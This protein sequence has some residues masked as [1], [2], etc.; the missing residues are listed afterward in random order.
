MMLRNRN[1]PVLMTAFGLAAISLAACDDAYRIAGEATKGG[2][3]SGPDGGSSASGGS[4]G[5]G[6]SSATGGATG[7]TG[8][9]GGQPVCKSDVIAVKGLCQDLGAFKQQAY[10]ACDEAGLSLNDYVPY[11]S[12]GTDSYYSVRYVCCPKPEA[13]PPPP[14]QCETGWKT[15]GGDSSCKPAGD[16]KQYAGED[17]EA[18]GTN[19]TAYSP[20]D[21]C[22]E[23]NYRSVQYCCGPTRPLPTT[24]PPSDCTTSSQGDGSS[25][26]PV[27]KWMQDAG[28]DCA[29]RGAILTAYSPYD[30]CGYG[31]YRS[32]EYTC[33]A[34][35]S[36]K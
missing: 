35:E 8:G 5:T 29:A 31:N 10:S 30:E 16:W 11:D 23:G 9:A 18:Q 25:C 14:P 17:C 36:A 22:G 1:R 32:L 24:P 26:K 4:S 20:Y 6:G 28:E 2:T 13:V 21:D 19:L 3:S 33:C 15:Q 34:P 12:C 7:S 27:G